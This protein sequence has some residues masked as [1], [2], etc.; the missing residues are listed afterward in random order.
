[1]AAKRSTRSQET[2]PATD[3]LTVTPAEEKVETSSKASA[4]V[5]IEVETPSDEPEVVSKTVE[6]E[7]VQTD[8]R[9]KL[10]KKTDKDDPFV[11]AN[12]AALEKAA[13]AVAKERGFEMNRGTSVGARL[14]ARA[15]KRV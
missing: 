1:M 3:D 5:N 7:K 14:I 11:P 6:A 2:K 9:A 10:A 15:Q 8:V 4:P 13:D 12:P